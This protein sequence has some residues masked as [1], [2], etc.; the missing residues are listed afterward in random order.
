MQAPQTLRIIA[1]AV[2]VA[3]LGLA[4]STTRTLAQHQPT[5]Q[6]AADGSAAQEGLIKRLREAGGGSEDIF[7]RIVRLMD[8]SRERL[9]VT[10][11][12]GET[13]QA[14][15]QQIIQELDAAIDIAKQN[16]RR[17]S[18]STADPQQEGEKRSEGQRQREQAVRADK[19]SSTDAAEQPSTGGEQADAAHGE[20]P[21]R[22]AR[23]WGNLPERDREAV[24]QGFK[25]DYLRKY[26]ELIEQYYRA[27][28]EEAEE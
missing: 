11:D 2:L 10:L 5:T 28:S 16:L 22:P 15:Q 14:V 9:A 25:E 3:S 13:T 1:F 26:G 19:S 23:S 21:S 20:T 12:A 17:G 18:P 7:D 6:P 4:A 24:I 8:T 27:L